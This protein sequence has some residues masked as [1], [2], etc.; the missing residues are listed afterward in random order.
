MTQSNHSIS[1]SQKVAIKS[2]LITIGALSCIASIYSLIASG[3]DT[4]VLAGMTSG[5]SL[6][7]MGLGLD[8]MIDQKKP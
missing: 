3:F 1:H 8:R 7:G 4:S 6:L 5:A 2:I